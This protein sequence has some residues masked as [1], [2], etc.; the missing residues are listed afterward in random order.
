MVA[1]DG[2]PIA[3]INI[4]DI[5]SASGFGGKSNDHENFYAFSSY[6][7]HPTISRFDTQ[8][9]NSEVY[10]DTKRILNPADFNITQRFY[11]T[12]YANDIQILQVMTK[13]HKHTTRTRKK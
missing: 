7:R 4:A 11:N 1:L 8:N 13:A 5:G 10:G 3:N 6:A 12:T 2:K 9:G